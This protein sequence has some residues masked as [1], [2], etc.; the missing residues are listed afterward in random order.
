MFGLLDLSSCNLPKNN[1][2]FSACNVC[3]SLAA[4]FGRASRILLTNDSIYLSLLIAAQ[5]EQLTYPDQPRPEACRPWSR[6]G[7]CLPEFKYPA[8]VSVLTAAVRLI[9]NL[10][11]DPSA[12]SKIPYALWNKRIRETE[13]DLR[14]LGLGIPSIENLVQEQH[15]RESEPGRELG[16]YSG[17][18]E[19]MYSKIFSQTAILAGAPDNAGYLAEVGKHL[20]R[21]AY[22]LDGYSDF[23]K[24]RNEGSFNVLNQLPTS[25]DGKERFNDAR[26]AVAAQVSHSL[27][28]IQQNILKVKFHRFQTPLQYTVTTGLR[29][30]TH[31]I[32]TSV[33]SPFSK[34]NLYSIAPL[35]GTM[36][37][38]GLRS[39]ITPLQTG[40][41]SDCCD[42]NSLIPSPQ[43]C[44]EAAFRQAVSNV[45]S[46]IQQGVEAAAVGGA[47]AVSISAIASHLSS[48]AQ[49]PTTD[50]TSQDTSS[51]SPDAQ[52]PTGPP[53]EPYTPAE[54]P[55]ETPPETPQP[56]TQPTFGDS[57]LHPDEVTQAIQW[58]VQHNRSLED[59]QHDLNELDKSRGGSGNVDLSNLPNDQRPVQVTT[60]T[61]ETTM[62]Q[63]DAAEYNAQRLI[64]GDVNQRANQIYNQLQSLQ[65]DSA[66]WKKQELDVGKRTVAGGYRLH[67]ANQD[68]QDTVNQIDQ[69]YAKPDLKNYRDSLDWQRALEDWRK[70]PE[71]QGTGISEQHAAELR[72]AQSDHFNRLEQLTGRK[73]VSNQPAPEPDWKER[74]VQYGDNQP[75]Y[76]S[77]PTSGESWWHKPSV[78]LDS[79]EQQQQKLIDEL[80]RLEEVKRTAINKM[81]SMGQAAQDGADGA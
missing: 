16:F 64:L 34:P 20:G 21:I 39:L 3:N 49:Q 32:L 72:Q 48:S 58:G 57:T 18:T 33:V 8:A 66:F 24:D 63:K 55:P 43:A 4:E 28:C 79:I 27:Q 51:S 60:P 81:K 26:Q 37:L 78:K 22:L 10:Y 76:A 9:D 70:T 45:T 69:K 35:I 40:D 53:E 47:A 74:V 42:C 61:G 50:T 30:K 17:L 2:N 38:V 54:Q 68:Y 67:E 75:T 1:R 15:R 80:K 59:I 14:Q 29:N 41:S 12:A 5:S 77:K 7:S 71:G 73:D 56:P 44:I 23:Q 31:R 13:R 46:H 6:D 11:D 65:G 25:G 52:E 36:A 19:E 62:T